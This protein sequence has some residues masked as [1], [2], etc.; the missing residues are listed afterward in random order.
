[1]SLYSECVHAAAVT[2]NETLPLR[3]RCAHFHVTWS[4]HPAYR[5]QRQ[6]DKAGSEEHTISLHKCVLYVEEKTGFIRVSGSLSSETVGGSD[7][8]T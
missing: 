1:M 6:T 2:G 5:A 7:G 3:F 8:Q 4:L